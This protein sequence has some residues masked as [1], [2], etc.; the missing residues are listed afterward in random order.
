[1]RIDLLSLEGPKDFHMHTT[2]CDGKNSAEEMVQSAISKGLKFVGISGHGFTDFDQRYCMSLAATADY[3]NE[4]CELASKYDG[5]IKLLRGIEQ[6][7]YGMAADETLA[8]VGGVV[9][10]A[11]SEG[12]A[13]GETDGSGG[14]AAGSECP[15]GATGE[16]AVHSADGAAWD[17]V[18]GS[19]HYIRVPAAG[20]GAPRE[21]FLGEDPGYY[22][23]GGYGYIPVDDDGE[24]LVAAA[25]RYFGGDIYSLCEAYFETVAQVV[26]QVQPDIIG[27]F[28]LISK[29]NRGGEGGSVGSLFDESHPRYVAAWKAAA[30]RLLETGVPFEI[31]TG[32]IARG[33]R[34]DP[35]PSKPI[36][37]YIKE[38]GGKLIWS[39]DSHAAGTICGGFGEY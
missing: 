38:R 26:D 21:D 34:N 32:A 27:H 29:L 16:G 35:Y 8:G 30:D 3:Y 17:Y 25:E 31:N 12:V 10:A 1:M 23:V 6:D 37:E 7:F 2:Y 33:Y 14:A 13:A 20:E 9:T 36:R 39:S 11:G 22:E 4:L 19:V 28:D 15:C 5:D 24:L 18:I